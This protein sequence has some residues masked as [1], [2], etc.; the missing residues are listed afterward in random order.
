MQFI[1]HKDG[2]EQ[3]IKVDGELHKYIFKVRRHNIEEPLY[4][5]NLED[6]NIYKYIITSTDKKFTQ[7]TLESY[8]EKIIEPNK[9][10]HIGWCVI[11]PKSIEKY[12][13]S[14]NEIGVYKITFIYCQ[15][16]QKQYKLNLE[17]I[18][19]LLINSSSQCGRSSIIKI[20]ICNSLDE[21]IQI[22]PQSY[23]FNFSSQN[24]S[25]YKQDIE[26]IIIG[27]EG[28]FSDEEVSKFNQENIVGID[29]QLIL[30]SETAVLSVASHILQ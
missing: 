18:E 22:Y 5:R 2:G 6:K 12:I 21:F 14:L 28:G 19:K 30:K 20:E 13:A 29:S 11:D 23:I 24:I 9:S 3:T 27:C 4:F 10:L 17:K 26:T 25:T 8:E 16:S 15:Y 7:L 1:Y